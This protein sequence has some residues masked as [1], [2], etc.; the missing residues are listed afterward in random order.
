ML[1]HYNSIVEHYT[2]HCN[3]RSALARWISVKVAPH[4]DA[5]IPSTITPNQ[6]TASAASLAIAMTV[7]L[8]LTPSDWSI[9]ALPSGAFLIMTYCILDHVDGQRARRLKR[10]TP[11]GEF[12][13]HGVDAG[14]VGLVAS[15][16]LMSGPAKD[17]APQYSVY[18]ISSLGIATLTL[19]GEQYMTGQLNLPRIGPVE[20]VFFSAFYMLACMLP[21]INILSY[22]IVEHV[23]GIEALLIVIS[24]AILGAAVY[25]LVTITGV[26]RQVWPFLMTFALVSIAAAVHPKMQALWM[27]ILALS[28]LNHASLII[29]AHLA[30]AP[31]VYRHGLLI[32]TAAFLLPGILIFST[33]Q[34]FWVALTPCFLATS[35]ARTW[36]SAWRNFRPVTR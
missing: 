18:F 36:H 21:E 13:D 20:G 5:W 8:Y 30:R 1:A 6:I 27:I 31:Q 4:V 17:I 33:T 32:I 14:V 3:D 15:A 7:I 35:T 23:S 11:W 16:V 28:I 2:Y 10:S 26:A 29:F 9:A 24:T 12:L 25:R 34:F 19:W 22:Q